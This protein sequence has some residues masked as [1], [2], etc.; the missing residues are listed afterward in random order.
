MGSGQL[1]DS[2][3]F[4]P[5]APKLA[6]DHVT[7]PVMSHE[8]ERVFSSEGLIVTL[9]RGKLS[10]KQFGRTQCVE[11]RIETGVIACLEETFEHVDI[12]PYNLNNLTTTTTAT[13]CRL[14]FGVT[15]SV[16]RPGAKVA[17][18]EGVSQPTWVSI[19][20]PGGRRI[21]CLR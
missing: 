14:A 10:A 7:I 17:A 3:N 16:S 9:L 12:L 11:S 1:S 21:R 13:I 18:G 6:R 19:S 4:N 2:K 15:C 20:L 8:S 5:R